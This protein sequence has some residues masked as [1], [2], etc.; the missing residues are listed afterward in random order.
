MIE[1]DFCF[2]L[3]QNFSLGKTFG[4]YVE[5]ILLIFV[6]IDKG[7]LKHLSFVDFS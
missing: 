7:G 6:L 5:T 3:I 4:G 1:S 2:K